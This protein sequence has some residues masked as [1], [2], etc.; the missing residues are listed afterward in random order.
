MCIRDSSDTELKL[1]AAAMDQ[2]EQQSKESAF[3]VALFLLEFIAFDL[4]ARI[5]LLEKIER[6]LILIP[7]PAKSGTPGA[8]HQH[9]DGGD[10]QS[11][12]Q[13]HAEIHAKTHA[14]PP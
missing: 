13:Q 6:G 1:T 12:E 8:F 5:A 3:Q 7:L 10:K 14:A 4:A 11:P 2:R 9:C